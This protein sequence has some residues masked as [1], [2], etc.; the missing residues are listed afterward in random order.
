MPDLPTP[1]AADPFESPVSQLALR[2]LHIM[3]AID[4]VAK[5][6]RNEAQGY[7]YV[8]A[9]AVA[10]AVREECVKQ[11]VLL[12]PSVR[13]TGRWEFQGRNGVIG[14]ATVDMTITAFDVATGATISWD[15]LGDGMDTGDKGIYKAMTGA[16]KYGLRNA[17][18]IPDEDD[19]ENPKGEPDGSGEPTRAAA[20]QAATAARRAAAP[21]AP[22]STPAAVPQGAEQAADA[23]RASHVA[24]AT[25]ALKRKIRA[26]AKEAP[27]GL[28]DNGLKILVF[29]LI[30]KASSKEWTMTDADKI[31]AA[32]E[33]TALVEQARGLQDQVQA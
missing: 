33:N 6:K 7:N 29:N 9:A 31:L 28:D 17:F 22:G 11:G 21:A 4:A 5:S 27:R 24:M 32:L 3:A 15:T 26:T 12:I 1:A 8:P 20:A 25:D 30:G 13:R 10:H 14:V 16:L 23:E 19:P 18:L 2:L